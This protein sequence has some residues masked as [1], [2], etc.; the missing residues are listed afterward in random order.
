MAK[1]KLSRFTDKE[2]LILMFIGLFFIGVIVQF[3]SDNIDTIIT[4]IAIIVGLT[5][6]FYIV[7]FIIYM[8][9]V[10][11]YKQ[12][13]YFIDTKV[14]YRVIHKYPGIWF[15]SKVYDELSNNFPNSRLLTNLLIPRKDSV[16][17]YSEIDILF[18]HTS[19]LYVLE[20]KNY[21]GFIF[22]GLNDEKWNVGYKNNNKRR[23]FEFLNPINQNKKHII[24]LNKYFSHEFISN[25]IFSEK[26]EI[27]S[28][29]DSVSYLKE[30]IN[31]INNLENKYTVD[32]LNEIY[33]EVKKINVY[34]KIG[35]HIER[36][37]FNEEKY[38]K[39]KVKK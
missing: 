34:E 25:I 29:I 26:T 7:K 17:E 19:G 21:K 30:F 36:I 22:G 5:V 27:N 13:K 14:P 2:L 23:T 38:S 18:L 10:K 3:I 11:K 20:L 35:K 8:S 32:E 1:K 6:T 33:E 4:I 16:N 12:T 39:Y 15:E 9:K 24:D 37:K 28:H 31:K